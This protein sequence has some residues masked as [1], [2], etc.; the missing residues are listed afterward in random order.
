MEET[1]NGQRPTFN[2]AVAASLCEARDKSDA[3]IALRTAK[4]LQL[5]SRVLR[6]E[7]SAPDVKVSLREGNLDAGF[8]EFLLDGEIEIALESARPMTHLAAPDDQL[9]LDGA[10]AE[11]LQENTGRRIVQDVR[12]AFAGRD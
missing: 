12:M 8:A 1:L 10:V 11:L 9:E 7:H 6:L 3:G 5:A 4:R 2:S